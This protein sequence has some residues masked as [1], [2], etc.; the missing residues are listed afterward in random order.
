MIKTII[1]REFLEHI[2]SLQFFVLMIISIILFAVGAWVAV[3]SFQEQTD[4]YN[5]QVTETYN[6]P[7]TVMTACHRAPG[8]FSFI[9]DGGL[10]TQPFQVRLRPRGSMSPDSSG[11]RNYKMM[12]VPNLDW[13]FIVKIVF[14]L[15]ALLLAY[16]SISGEKEQGTLRLIMSN[17][18]GRARIIAAKYASILFALLVPLAAGMLVSLIIITLYMPALFSPVLVA[19]L[20]I[21]VLLSS[22]YFSIFILLG[23]TLSA[24]IT[25]SSVVLLTL[26]SCWLCFTSIVPGMAAIV[27]GYISSI[28]GEFE[29]AQKT[30]PMIQK[31]IW[32][33]IQDILSRSEKGEFTT[34]EEIL[35]ETDKAF[36]AGQELLRNHFS[37][38]RNAVRERNRMTR[39]VSRISPVSLFQFAAESL[40]DSGPLRQDRFM[41][42]IQR[43]SAVYDDYI[44]RKTGKLITTSVYS[45]G[46]STEFKGEPFTI[47]SPRAEEY[48]GDKSDFPRFRERPQVLLA[49]IRNALLD[50]AGLLIWNL[51]LAGCAFI[52]MLRCDVR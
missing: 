46:M 19:R 10:R 38:Y 4:M 20:L 9:A 45:F 18:L 15:F 35:A 39:L 25:K 27:S 3:D 40:A 11:E 26:L 2:H 34:K 8:L 47:E 30:G 37:E 32:D 13:A 43:Y 51:L 12:D 49:D 41:Q 42:E 44:L 48:T 5:K 24:L 22:G 23:L 29:M 52:A 17:S 50:I 36:M 6:N 7:S 16:R 28:P 33:R 14:S 31:D 1:T 21:F